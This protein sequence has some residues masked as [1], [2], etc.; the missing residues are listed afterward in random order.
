M[1]AISG[2]LDVDGEEVTEAKV[3]GVPETRTAELFDTDAKRIIVVANKFQMGFDQPKICGDEDFVRQARTN[4][5]GDLKAVLGDVMMGALMAIL[6]DSQDMAAKFGERPDDY[7]RITNSDLLSMV[8]R[9]CNEG[10][11]E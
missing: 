10:S 3:N 2:T 11:G 6:S 7:L 5:M 8:Y 1:V 4:S 9:G